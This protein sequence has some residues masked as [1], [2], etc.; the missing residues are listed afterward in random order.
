MLVPPLARVSNI[1]IWGSAKS[2]N[3]SVTGLG[4]QP[5]TT[6]RAELVRSHGASR[7]SQLSQAAIQGRFVR[8]MESTSHD[9]FAT[10]AACGCGR[11]R[12]R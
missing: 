3:D 6:G 12:L 5:A 9:R 4:H 7:R 1:E 2:P 10:L 11:I 8:Q